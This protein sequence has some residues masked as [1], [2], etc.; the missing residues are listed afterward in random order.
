VVDMVPDAS[1]KAL[2]QETIDSLLQ[3]Q[4]AHANYMRAFHRLCQ[5]QPNQAQEIAQAAVAYLT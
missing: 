5:T 2:A 1:A 3:S 4:S